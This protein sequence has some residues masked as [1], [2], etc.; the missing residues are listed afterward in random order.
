MNGRLTLGENIADLAG[1]SIAYE[2]FQNT[3]E[4]KANTVI[5]GFT[6]DQ[7]FFINWAQVWRN[8]ILPESAAQRILTDSH[9]PSMFRTNGP[10]QNIDAFYKAF[11][12]N[13]GDKMYVAP[14]D[15]IRVW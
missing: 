14:Q 7:R 6:A 11:N 2:A 13:E 4:A 12:V 5:N 3:A 10:L 15:R 1:L 8:N 9:S